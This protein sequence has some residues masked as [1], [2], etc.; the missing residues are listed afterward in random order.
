MKNNN[1]N[2]KGLQFPV[3]TE[4]SH[5]VTVSDPGRL[6]KRNGQK[7]KITRPKKIKVLKSLAKDWNYSKAASAINVNRSTLMRHIENDEQFAAAVQQIKDGFIDQVENTSVRVALIPDHKGFNDRKLLLQTHRKEYA[8]KPDSTN[9]QVNIVNQVNAI[10]EIRSILNK[11]A[12]R[13][14]T[15]GEQDL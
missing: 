5:F 15:D 4:E 12:V 14:N 3:D 6:L 13:V 2:G 11:N 1:E 8:P 7:T 10:P 9:V